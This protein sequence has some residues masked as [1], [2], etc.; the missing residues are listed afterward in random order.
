MAHSTDEIQLQDWIRTRDA[1]AFNELA[2]RYSGIVFGA[3]LRITGNRAEAEDAT[4]ECF[5]TLARI[6]E[7]PRTPIG[8]WLHRVATNRALDRVKAQRRR[9]SRE[10]RYA[11][12]NAHSVDPTWNDI[13]T[14]VD[15]AISELPD[16]LRVPIV[17]HFLEGKSY[18]AV[19][20]SSGTSRQ[21]V[22]YRVK[23][24]V[25]LLRKTLRK[26]GVH[27]ALS[28]LTV[29]LTAQLAEAVTVPATTVASLGKLA[30]AGAA[31]PTSA[32]SV[33]TTALGGIVMTKATIAS[34]SAAVAIVCAG[35]VYTANLSENSPSENL[36]VATNTTA[37]SGSIAESRQSESAADLAALTARL[38]QELTQANARVAK[39]EEALEQERTARQSI[40]RLP[41]GSFNIDVD[42]IS[43][44]AK[45]SLSRLYDPSYHVAKKMQYSRNRYRG[46]F[47]LMRLPAEVR[48]TVRE[49]LTE[50]IGRLA[51]DGARRD[52][53]VS[54]VF[55]TATLEAELAQLLT[56]EELDLWRDYENDPEFFQTRQ[57]TIVNLLAN[58]PGLN[59]ANR[60]LVADIV[61]E[62]WFNHGDTAGELDARWERELATIES[63]R[64]RVL[65]LSEDAEQFALYDAYVEDQQALIQSQLDRYA[66][67]GEFVIGGSSVTGIGQRSA[68]QASIVVSGTIPTGQT[69]EAV[70]GSIDWT[71]D[72]TQQKASS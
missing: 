50:N 25:R 27:V 5:E 62:E 42:D 9:V 28:A 29:M 18:T 6:K 26:R 38:S 23:E 22:T 52:A 46:L 43:K 41:S 68:G 55:D 34:V 7:V 39:L 31:S 66:Q 32:A 59:E 19:A 36:D 13:D 64:Q 45:K 1:D 61:A 37:E 54:G 51:A 47:S 44:A 35:V 65:E 14:L 11:G 71:V 57:D 15:E 12:E 20:Q 58:V 8:A 72:V 2:R 21:V 30:L 33:G 63:A 56:E 60:N 17:A 10:A 70:R 49:L 16:E 3:C 67:T 69:G 24:G 40:A 53:L 48:S 4:Q